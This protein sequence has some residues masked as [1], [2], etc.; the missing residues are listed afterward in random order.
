MAII[1]APRTRRD[2]D[3]R[4]TLDARIAA[5]PFYGR[6]ETAAGVTTLLWRV[7]RTAVSHP[8]AWIGPCLQESSLIVRRTTVPLLLSMS[9]F[10]LGTI[11]AII[12]GVVE[13]IGSVDRAGGANITGWPREPGFWVTS[14]ILAGVAGSAMTA[15]LGARKIRDEL[16]A[17]SVLGVD[18]IR[19]LIVPRVV[20][21]TLITPVMG[22]IAVLTGMAVSFVAWPALL[23]NLTHSAF[24]DAMH[25][26]ADPADLISFVGRC[27]L[28]GLFVGIVCCYKGISTRGGAEGVGRAVN[29]AVLITFMGLWALNGLWN[30]VFLSNVPSL[31]VLRG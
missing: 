31:Q 30:L 16:D 9:A 28:T 23:P 12:G 8:G 3:A 4:P 20:A 29:E 2:H 13:A 22:L 14:M 1:D 17:M 25:S 10:A 6:L 19:T 15:D 24:V 5:L 21:L 11:I 27:V 26:F 7:A 18:T